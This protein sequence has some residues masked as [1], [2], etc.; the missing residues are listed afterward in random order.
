M[1]IARSAG[2]RSANPK[3]R[4]TAPTVVALINRVKSTKAQTSAAMKF[5]TSPEKASFSNIASAN[6]SD[7]APRRPPHHITVRKPTLTSVAIL[8][9]DNM[10]STANVSSPRAKNAVTSNTTKVSHMSP[11]KTER[12]SGTAI[13][14]S[15]KIIELAQ[16]PM[17]S[18]VSVR[19]CQPPLDIPVRPRDPI[20]RA[21]VTTAMTP[22]T[23]R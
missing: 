21:A 13:P 23:C 15:T 14:T 9:R 1:R 17:F 5:R 10:G 20:T 19:R 22:E 18:Q 11:A 8:V 12:I 3:N 6:A 4:I 2:E 7:T 16:K